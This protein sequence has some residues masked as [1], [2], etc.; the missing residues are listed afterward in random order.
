MDRDNVVDISAFRQRRL[1]KLQSEAVDASKRLEKR[2]RVKP[3]DY[4]LMIGVALFFDALQALFSLIPFLGWGLSV[5][6]AVFAWLTFY[7][8]TSIKGWGL[9]DTI[10]QFIIQYLIPFVELIPILNV[11]PTWTLRVVLQLSFLKAEDVVYNT[12]K[13]KVDIEKI[14]HLYI[15]IKHL[16]K[17]N[18]AA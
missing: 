13:G 16:H 7:V 8:W 3:H 1:A 5:L 11:L 6:I 17:Q 4:G 18:Q 2:N 10:K 12:S 15:E 14:A 9:S